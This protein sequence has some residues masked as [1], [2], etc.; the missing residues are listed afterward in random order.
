MDEHLISNFSLYRLIHVTTSSIG[1]QRSPPRNQ[2]PR[3]PSSMSTQ[4]LICTYTFWVHQHQIQSKRLRYTY[5]DQIHTHSPTPTYILNTI[6]VIISSLSTH[7]SILANR[8]LVVFSSSSIADA[9]GN[10]KKLLRCRDDILQMF[11]VPC[12]F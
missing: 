3:T 9:H 5:P 8:V 4:G 1:L 10:G 7:F 6:T 11:D 2:T 12:V